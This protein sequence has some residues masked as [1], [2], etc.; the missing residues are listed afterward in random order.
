LKHGL[1][2]KWLIIQQ[3]D[4]R[5]DQ[6]E[7]DDWYGRIREYYKPVGFLEDFWTE[8][9]AVWSWRLRRLIRCE[10]GC[11]ARSLAEYRQDANC[12][13][14]TMRDLEQT[15]PEA[16]GNLQP[17][18][19]TDHLCLPSKEELDRLVRC[20]ARIERE[21]NHAIAELERLQMRRSGEIVPAP[22]SLSVSAP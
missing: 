16:E 4:G 18:D 13:N 15:N 21:L 3:P 2:S 22:I 10:S 8:K 6:A 19:V 11:I 17:K 12:H 1:F 5:E 7:P 14:I 9:I 20:E